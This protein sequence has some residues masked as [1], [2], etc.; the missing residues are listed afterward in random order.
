M[1]TEP[2]LLPSGSPLVEVP[3]PRDPLVRVVA[4][5]QF[6]QILSILK[7]ESV[8]D[9]QKTLHSDYPHLDRHNVRNLKIGKDSGSNV[10]DTI[11]WRFSDQP[12]SMKWRVSLGTDFVALETC[13]YIDRDDFMSRLRKV[14]ESVEEIFGPVMAQRLGLRYIDRLEGEALCRIGDLV[15]P[16][17]LGILQADGDELEMLRKATTHLMT[18]AQFV[19]EEGVIQGRWGNLPPNATYD[20]DLLQAIA[21][22]SWVLDLDMFTSKAVPFKSKDLVVKTKVFANHMYSVFR[23]MITDEFLKF[24]GGTV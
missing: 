14:L 20:P 7:A 4:Q 3:L 16:G 5:A 15:Q 22:P 23:Q 11:I 24:Y 8:A 9:F 19:A 6:P 12:V 13:R 17:I 18:E 2:T 21:E 10:S 1:Q